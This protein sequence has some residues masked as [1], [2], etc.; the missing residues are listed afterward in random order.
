MRPTWQVLLIVY[1]VAVTLNYPWEL[2]QSPLFT[3]ASHIGSVWLHCFIS[4][5]GDGLMVL[6]LFGFVW[7]ALGCRDWFVRPGLNGY[8]V[9][10]T[11]GA[12]LALIVEWVAVHQIHRW[13]YTEA[14]PRLPVLE[15][16]IIPL[17][18]M[19]LLPPLVFRIAAAFSTHVL[20]RSTA[21]ERL[22]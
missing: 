20:D 9:L 7:L 11:A 2:L 15:V 18:Q 14:M 3:P 12:G 5:L 10:L 1:L 4:S 8:A 17:F 22:R 21:G 13:T 16:G 19:M 6:L